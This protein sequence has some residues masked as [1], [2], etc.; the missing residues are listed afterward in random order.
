MDDILDALVAAWTAS[1]IIL[2]KAQTLPEDPQLDSKDLRME[3]V[4]PA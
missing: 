3:I 2:Q 4:Y 1:Q